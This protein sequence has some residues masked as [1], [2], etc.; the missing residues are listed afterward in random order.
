MTVSQG[1]ARSPLRA[2]VRT[3]Q[4][5]R[6]RVTRA[7]CL[8]RMFMR[9][10]SGSMS[11]V[12]TLHPGGMWLKQRCNR[13]A[14]NAKRLS[15]LT[16]TLLSAS[17]SGFAATYS[18]NGNTGFGGP[19]GLGSLTL[20]DDGTTLSGTITKGPNGFNDVLVLYVD[21]Q[22][23]GFSDTSGF[24]DDGGGGDA[25]RKAISGYTATDNGG[26]PG[27]SLMTFAS[28]FL[29]DYAI[30]LGPSAASFGGV[31]QLANGGANSFP[32]AG[33][34]N[35]SNLG[36]ANSSTYTFSLNL[37][38]IGVTAGQSF[39]LFGTYISGSGYRSDEAI[40][41]N[42]V[43]ASGQGWNPFTQTGFVTYTAAPEPSSI[44]LLVL[45]AAAVV[46]ARRK[47]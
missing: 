25:L 27:R 9:W 44:G 47:K 10:V 31:F 32:Y 14:M 46:A 41:G 35:L 43:G 13:T 42:D 20:T 7:A 2:T 40:A 15:L 23:G 3:T 28:G 39:E 38:Q 19:I 22:A 33:S 17:L 45:G 1:R 18:G 24:F 12:F 5:D 6:R 16:A 30:A 29:P 36:D 26:G 21:S 34:A 4:G 8:H 11:I 37:S